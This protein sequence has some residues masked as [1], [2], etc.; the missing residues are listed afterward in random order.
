MIV[1]DGVVAGYRT[2]RGLIK[3]LDGVSFTLIG[4]EMLGIAGESGC[5]RT[6]PLKLLHG[7]FDDGLELLFGQVYWRDPDGDD[8][9]DVRDFHRRLSTWTARA[10]S[11]C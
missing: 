10:T 11:R 9:V 3:A 8:R 1:V 7:R 4:G 2:R 6:T 5:G